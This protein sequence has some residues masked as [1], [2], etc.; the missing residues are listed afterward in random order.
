MLGT[1]F[2]FLHFTLAS[3]WLSSPA[4]QKSHSLSINK[5]WGTQTKQNG[6]VWKET[7][8][9]GL[10]G[11]LSSSQFQNDNI[12]IPIPTTRHLVEKTRKGSV[13]RHEP[14]R[15]VIAQQATSVHLSIWVT[16]GKPGLHLPRLCLSWVQLAEIFIKL[17]MHY[18]WHF[19]A[20]VPNLLKHFLGWG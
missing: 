17:V 1:F 13:V 3:T 7:F 19:G 8:L 14:G 12:H 18:Y 10:T 5:V 15:E 6:F 4:D 11:G 20:G 16:A 2:V 9:S